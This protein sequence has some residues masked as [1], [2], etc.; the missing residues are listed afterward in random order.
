MTLPL[1][2]GV[3]PERLVA[4]RQ[5]FAQF[6]AANPQVYARLVLLAQDSAA[7]GYRFGLKALVERL[8]WDGSLRTNGK[9]FKLD[10]SYTSQYARLLYEQEPAL[11]PY[12]RVRE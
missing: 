1:F 4:P 5:T 10:N 12:F 9:P 3:A 6:H 11:R 7:L 8:R 2:D